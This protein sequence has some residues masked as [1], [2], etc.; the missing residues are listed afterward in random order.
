M[1]FYYVTDILDFHISDNETA[2][3][4][5]FFEICTEKM[6]SWMTFPG[7][8]KQLVYFEYLWDDPNFSNC[9]C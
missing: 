9:H 5:N 1:N 8:V 7:P 2:A 6:L 3:L 4:L